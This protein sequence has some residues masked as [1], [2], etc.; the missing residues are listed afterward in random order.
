MLQDAIDGLLAFLDSPASD[1]VILAAVAALLVL[2]VRR[3]AAALRSGGRRTTGVR[4]VR[5]NVAAAPGRGGRSLR[6]DTKAQLA[7]LSAII[8]RA[9][10]HSRTASEI[11]AAASI[12]IDAAEMALNRLLVEISGVM[13][14]GVRPSVTPRREMAM[15]RPRRA[16]TPIRALAA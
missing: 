7:R 3:L 9:V 16:E 10:G 5:A 11:Q 6:L 2:G 1:Y 12:Q 14:L 8:D 15:H 13:H 4:P